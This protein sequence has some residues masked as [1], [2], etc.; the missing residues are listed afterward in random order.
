MLFRSL[1][2]DDKKVGEEVELSEGNGWTHTWTKLPKKAKGKDIKYEVKEV[3]EV[4][5]YTAEIDNSDIGNIRILNSHT[6]ETTEIKGKKTWNDGDNRDGNRP[7]EITVNLLANGKKIKEAKATADTNWEYSFTDLPKYEGGKEIEYT[8]TE[9]TVK[10]YSTDIKGYDIENNYT[11]K[12][13]SVTVTKRW[14]DSND[15]DKIRPD[16]IKVQLYANGEKKGE[17]V[18]L[19]AENKWSY[20]WKDLPQKENGKDIKYT[21]KEVGKLKGYTV[22]VDDKNHGNII[23]TNT[24]TPK[25]ITNPE[26]GD[27]NRLIP[28]IL[29]LL[30]SVTAF[31]GVFT[32]RKLRRSWL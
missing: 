16:S 17:A 14:N 24:H 1:Y 29:M 26:T 25:E 31:M 28:Y 18:Q 27:T 32:F 5:G 30:L 21:V 15:K 7:K 13:T 6:P 20:T 19:K 3:T 2:G 4:D 12:K 11:P 8:V 10:G 23:I 22:K 9:N